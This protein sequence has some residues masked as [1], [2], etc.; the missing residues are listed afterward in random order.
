M[1]FENYYFA[2]TNAA[3]KKPLEFYAHKINCVKV[4]IM[5][6]AMVSRQLEKKPD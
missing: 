1:H 3:L 6:L 2:I 4:M 5:A